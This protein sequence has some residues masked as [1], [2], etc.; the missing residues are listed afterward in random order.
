MGI[1][2]KIK[3]LLGETVTQLNFDGY[4]AS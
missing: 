2:S 1:L 3:S 4:G